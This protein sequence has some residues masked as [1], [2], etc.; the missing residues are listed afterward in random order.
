[1]EELDLKPAAWVYEML[2]SGNET[3]YKV[4]AGKRKYYDIPSKSYK[5]I[6]GT[7]SFI[8]LDNLRQTN[9][10]WKNAGSTIFDL[11]DGIAGV[12][13]HSKMN[14]F[15]AEVVEGLNKAYG[16]AEKD[17]RGLVVGNDSNE[18]FRRVQTWR[19]CLCLPLSKNTTKSI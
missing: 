4:E 13:F 16:I 15:G 12:E 10:I 5:V 8:I 6:P 1:M 19:C 9:V 17:F 18:A 2:E 3:F 7:E 14:T 11:G